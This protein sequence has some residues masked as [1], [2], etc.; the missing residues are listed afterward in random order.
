MR[1][2][3]FEVCQKCGAHLDPGEKCDCEEVKNWWAAKLQS[4]KHRPIP[5]L[6]TT[7]AQR[8][9]KHI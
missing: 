2:N 6:R 7:T 1:R 5:P 3:Y 4:Q 9:E 8:E